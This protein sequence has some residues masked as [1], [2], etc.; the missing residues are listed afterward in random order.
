MHTWLSRIFT[1][2]PNTGGT[3]L[4]AV[5]MA[6]RL[7]LQQVGA[8]ALGALLRYPEPDQDHRQLACPCGRTAQYV[9]LRAKTLVTA[10]GTVKLRRAY[11][12]CADCGEGRCPSSCVRS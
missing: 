11:Y 9:G 10:Q 6:L 8:S 5:E 12:L 2:S 3:D 4:E 7:A 1:K